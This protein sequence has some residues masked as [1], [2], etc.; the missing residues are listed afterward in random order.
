MLM[1]FNVDFEGKL[2]KLRRNQKSKA[3]KET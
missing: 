2:Q 3:Q 1:I